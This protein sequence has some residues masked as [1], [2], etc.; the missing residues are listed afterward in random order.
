M[1]DQDEKN[2]QKKSR[3]H[4]LFFSLGTSTPGSYTVTAPPTAI[5]LRAMKNLVLLMDVQQAP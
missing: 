3:A 2:R 1:G 4:D 5:I